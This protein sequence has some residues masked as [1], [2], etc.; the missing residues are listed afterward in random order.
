MITEAR[1]SAIVR[2]FQQFHKYRA[3]DIKQFTLEELKAAHRRIGGNDDNEPYR[4]AMLK[5]IADL[6]KL[7]DRKYGS[8]VRAL[9]Y[10][11][12][13]A[14]GVIGTLLALYLAG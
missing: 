2:E 13:L 8:W 7:G 9:G 6:E 14:I 11:V 1:T 3:C 5:R 10:I 4:K 12:T